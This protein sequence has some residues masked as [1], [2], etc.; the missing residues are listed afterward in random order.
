MTRATTS[1]SNLFRR[2]ACPGSHAAEEGLPEEESDDSREGTLLHELD[3]AP[4][5]DRS[6]LSGDQ[7]D[8]LRIASEGDDQ[9]FKLV[10]RSCDLPE[11]EPYEEGWEKEFWLYEGMRRVFPGHC[12]RWRWYPKPRVLVIIDKKFGRKDVTPAESNLQLRAYAVMAHKK[13]WDFERCLVAINQPRK[14]FDDRLTVAEYA[15]DQI[16]AARAH[17]K[18]IYDRAL[19]PDQPRVAGEHCQYCK[20]RVHCDAYRARYL[21]LAPVADAGVDAFTGRLEQLDDEQVDKVWQA[22]QFASKIEGAAKSVILRRKESGGMPMYELGNT[23]NTSKITAPERVPALLRE[24]AGLPDEDI[25]QCA[26]YGLTALVEKVR[27]NTGCTQKE[28][29]RVVFDA[30]KPVLHIEPKAPSLQRIKDWSPEL[31]AAV[32]TQEAL[33]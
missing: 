5:A 3:A 17:L 25:A 27:G 15:A 13:P 26:K 22:I 11:D 31:P 19:L 32:E 33:L 9:L 23:G 16:P 21:W 2:E 28:A 30:L 18:K 20:A 1:A 7:R 6:H 12:D 8:V 24:K 29:R 10:C 4:G 14:P